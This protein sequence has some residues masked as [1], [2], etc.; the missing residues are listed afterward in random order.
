MDNVQQE[1]QTLFERV[2]GISW[3]SC[4]NEVMAA[5][6]A[7]RRAFWKLRKDSYFVPENALLDRRK[8]H[9]SPSGR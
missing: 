6:E 8:E 9:Q 3:V 1:A 7:V 4:K 2:Q 5:P